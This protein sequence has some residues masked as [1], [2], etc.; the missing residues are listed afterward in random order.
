VLLQLLVVPPWWSVSQRQALHDAATIAGLRRFELVESPVALAF[1]F[2][3]D[4]APFQVQG[5][6]RATSYL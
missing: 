5:S 6:A 2:L 3:M 1:K 4:F